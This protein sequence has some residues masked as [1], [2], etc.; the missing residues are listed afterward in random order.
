LAERTLRFHR[1]SGVFVFHEE[2]RSTLSTLELAEAL[3]G[4]IVAWRRQIHMRP[5]LG[6]Y[7]ERTSALVAELLQREGLEVRRGVG[8]TGVVGRLGTGRPCVAIRADMDALPL[9]E[10]NAVPYASQVPGVMHACG[11]DGNTAMALGAAGIL[12][13]LAER[14]AGEVRFL[15][16]PCEEGADAEGKSGAQRMIDDGA[17]DGVDAVLTM[18]VASTLPAGRVAVSGGHIMAAADSWEAVLTGQ[19]CHGA[20]PQ[21]GLDPFGLLAQVIPA[22]YAIVA[23]RVDPLR[24]AVVSI[25]AV[26]GGEAGNIIPAEV[27]LRGTLRSFDDETRRLLHGELERA[28]ALARALGGDY[29]L[30]LREGVPAT[31]NDP[32]IAEAVAAAAGG[33]LG[34]SAVMPQEAGMGAEDFA[35]ML[36]RA[37]GA[38]FQFGVQRDGEQRRHHSPDFDFDDSVLY[39]GAAVLAEAAC[40]L[41][42]S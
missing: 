35:W 34:S 29:A 11:H 28:L 17:L 33:L 12:A 30:A 40:R 32:A 2:W 14:P 9:Q 42:S 5:E 8:R 1:E 22:I 36:Q 20:Y 38:A 26:H 19:G 18:H 3:R 37:P 6:F 21:L 41:L 7:E 4:E 25:G 15:F 23:R 10:V 16:Q 24:P 13:R 39:Q 31:Y 27:R